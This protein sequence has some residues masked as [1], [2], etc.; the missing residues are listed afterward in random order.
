[1]ERFQR[2]RKESQ[3][4]AFFNPY[5]SKVLFFTYSRDQGF[6][7]VFAVVV[8]SSRRR[9]SVVL[10]FHLRHSSPSWNQV[11]VMRILTKYLYVVLR[12]SCRSSQLQLT[13]IA[14]LNLSHV[15]LKLLIFKG[16]VCVV[17]Y[18]AK[19]VNPTFSPPRT[20]L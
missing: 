8:L 12:Y 15:L 6:F 14:A 9:Q 18:R 1:M 17:C 16:K 19:R 7:L 4:F 2:Y 5:S 13:G 3:P 11:P 20:D 10:L